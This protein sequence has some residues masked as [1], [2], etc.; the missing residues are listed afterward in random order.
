MNT[1]TETY[2]LYRRGVDLLEAGSFAAA[3]VPLGKVVRSDPDNLSAREAFGRAL[4]R[5]GQ[6]DRA[7]GEFEAVVDRQPVNDY[8]HFC[9]GRAL[10]KI[11]EDDRAYHHLAIAS[12]LVPSRHDYRVYRERMANGTGENA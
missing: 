12:N 10:T 2:E 11:G 7:V 8:A 9:L 4:F 5:S 1:E 6:F 3:T